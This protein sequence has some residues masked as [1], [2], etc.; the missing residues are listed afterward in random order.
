MSLSLR[1]RLTDWTGDGM[2]KQKLKATT[3]SKSR[4]CIFAVNKL[5]LLLSQSVE[6]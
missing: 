3:R 4:E 2:K 1:S 5:E 6:K